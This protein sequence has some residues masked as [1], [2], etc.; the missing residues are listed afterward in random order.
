MQ[1]GVFIAIVTDAHA[2]A[3]LRY[4]ELGV[5]LARRGWAL[6]ELVLNTK[7]VEGIREFVYKKRRLLA[8]T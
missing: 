3:H 1:K 4:I 2:P 5:G 7:D 8:A 6:P